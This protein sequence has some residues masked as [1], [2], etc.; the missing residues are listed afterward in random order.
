MGALPFSRESSPPK[1]WPVPVFM[2]LHRHH[3]EV[4]QAECAVRLPWGPLKHCVWRSC[5]AF[6]VCALS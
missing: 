2:A 5:L 1:M 3:P 6:A 4:V